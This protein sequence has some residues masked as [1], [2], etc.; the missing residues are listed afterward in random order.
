MNKKLGSSSSS[1]HHVTLGD[2][3][4]T[5]L[6]KFSGDDFVRA[7]NKRSDWNTLFLRIFGRAGR[8]VKLKN[9]KVVLSLD[10]RV[11]VEIDE[12]TVLRLIEDEEDRDAILEKDDY[13]V[14]HEDKDMSAIEYVYESD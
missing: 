7:T 9:A 11:H 12:G 4:G 3:T 14:I 6:L 5:I 1:L 13:T 8:I 2:K 10:R